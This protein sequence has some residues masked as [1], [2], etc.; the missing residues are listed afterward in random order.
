[1]KV[2]D[3]LTEL[4]ETSFY[5]EFLEENKDAFFSAGFFIIDL[6]KKSETLQLDF[7]IKSRKKVA[8]F[9]FPW[10]NPKIHDDKIE[11]MEPQDLNNLAFDID[12]LEEKANESI[13]AH[14]G[15]LN[16]T[17]I[18]AII[19]GNEWNLTC[20]DNSLG[21]IGIKYNSIT[22]EETSYNSDSLMNIV[23]IEK[24]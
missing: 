15:V 3:L 7:F 5:K 2:K 18:I 20:M 24:K 6:E 21:I 23:K 16:P 17:K 8:A 14:N 19:K 9:E 10:K 4:K 13:K 1:M 22:G 11:S 12:D